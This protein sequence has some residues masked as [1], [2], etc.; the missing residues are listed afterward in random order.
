M[1]PYVD[2]YFKAGATEKGTRLMERVAEIYSENLDYYYA[3]SPAFR[4]Y[5][6]QDVQTALGI[7]KR[8]SMIATENKQE[9]LA[10]KLDTLFNLKLKAFH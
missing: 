1:L 8:M 3:F 2:I 10:A 5:F 6:E 9:R 4:Q 7:I